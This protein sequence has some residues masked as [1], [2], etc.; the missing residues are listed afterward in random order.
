MEE[1]H[2]DNLLEK[3]NDLAKAAS[4]A[5]GYRHSVAEPRAASSS[6]AQDGRWVEFRPSLAPAS[7]LTE[8]PEQAHPRP[9]AQSQHTI[10][11]IESEPPRA[12]RNSGAVFEA[13]AALTKSLN[14]ELTQ[15]CISERATIGHPGD[16]QIQAWKLSDGAR[17]SASPTREQQDDDSEITFLKRQLS[18]TQQQVKRQE[19]EIAG[20]NAQLNQRNAE[21][22]RL[23]ELTQA[24][25]VGGKVREL[26]SQLELQNAQAE[27]RLARGRAISS[28]T[29]QRSSMSSR[30]SSRTQV[31]DIASSSRSHSTSKISA[32]ER[33]LDQES[34]DLASSAQL[35]SNLL[36]RLE[37]THREAWSLQPSE[38]HALRK[39]AG[40]QP[41]TRK[42]LRT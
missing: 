29:S 14:E 21:V 39:R 28:G 16:F 6:P 35:A 38:L 13:I 8:Q 1:R 37:G 32:V 10:G 7:S 22:D 26:C 3:L 30:I 18:T 15:G 11:N 34:A 17:D 12:Y 5:I 19:E 31:W 42:P 20:L 41:C 4:A 23:K 9:S 27:L 25:S 2:L 40:S 33:I 24:R 36:G